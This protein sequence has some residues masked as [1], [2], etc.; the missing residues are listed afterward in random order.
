[1]K[2]LTITYSKWPVEGGINIADGITLSYA[3]EAYKQ[4]GE[5]TVHSELFILALRVLIKRGTI[6]YNDVQLRYINNDG[7]I[8]D[9]YVDEHGKVFDWPNDFCDI[10]ELYLNELIGI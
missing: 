8:I 6:P 3:L 1:M 10:S 9:L 4:G 5:Y 2:K 7:K